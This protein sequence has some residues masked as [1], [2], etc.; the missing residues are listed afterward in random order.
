MSKEESAIEVVNKFQDLASFAKSLP[1]ESIFYDNCKLCN[2]KNK[3]EAEAMAERGVS[4][5]QIHRFIT[6]EKKEDI[7]YS[8]V[9]NHLI[10][11][12]GVKSDNRRLKEYASQVAKWSELA[13]TDE[14]IL[15]RYIN[16]LDREANLLLAE[17]K[18]IPL[19]ERRKNIETAIKVGQLIGVFR[20]QLRKLQTEKR[21]VELVITSLNRII[22]IKLEDGST[23]EV[24]KVLMDIVDQLK[25]E[26]GELS[27][28]GD[29]NG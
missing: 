18:E 1:D 9:H 10:N 13:K 28:E 25:K 17:A 2:S 8:S 15:N 16:M 26:V 21:P 29:E 24:R 4:H 11:H 23:P 19:V 27:I 12:F 5:L 6:A 20:E 7:S 22:Q 14:A 3:E